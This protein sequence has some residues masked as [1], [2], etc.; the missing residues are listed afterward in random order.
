MQ[1]YISI[2]SFL[3]FLVPVITLTICHQIVWHYHDFH[4]VPFIDGKASVSMIGRGENTI[5]IFRSGFFIF[6]SISIF[7]YF[8]ISNFFSA[9][10]IKNKLKIYSILANLFLFIYIV[11][12]G[13]EGNFFETS[14]RVSIILY[15][16]IIY[17]AH[18][19]LTNILNFLR[20]KRNLNFNQIYLIIFYFIIFLMT[21]LMIIGLPWVNP[22][23]KYPDQLKNIIEWNFFLL[24]VLF[25]IPLSILFYQFKNRT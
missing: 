12:L 21:I 10:K 14:R 25:Y 7:F 2:C 16:A 18:F 3:L 4:T 23:F 24:T 22:L 15:I 8:K 6:L 17:L 9:I 13:R 5:G 11:T 1:K 19:H 20:H